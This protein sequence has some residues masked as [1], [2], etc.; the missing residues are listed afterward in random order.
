MEGESLFLGA[1]SLR[2]RCPADMVTL[3]LGLVSHR[4]EVAGQRLALGSPTVRVMAPVSQLSARVVTFMNAVDASTFRDTAH[5]FITELTGAPCLLEVGRRRIVIIAG[6]KVVGF[7]LRL[8]GLKPEA[9]MAL[10]EQGL[11]GRRH[12]GCGL[13]LPARIGRALPG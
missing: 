7:G 6:R 5:R 10:Q 13:F 8:G 3:F 4:L 1:G 11:G 9:A 2:I 12:M